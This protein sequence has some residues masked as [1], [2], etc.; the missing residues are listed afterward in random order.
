MKINNKLWTWPLLNMVAVYLAPK[1]L[2]K[3]FFQYSHLLK[4]Y[5]PW[6]NCYLCFDYDRLPRSKPLLGKQN[7]VEF[8]QSNGLIARV[9]RRRKLALFVPLDWW[10]FISKLSWF[11]RS[12]FEGLDFHGIDHKVQACVLRTTTILVASIHRLQSRCQFEL[13]L[14]QFAELK[15]LTD[16]SRQKLL[17]HT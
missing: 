12:R 11:R 14:S 1:W 7:S 3:S 13:T 15:S 10:N 6:R 4:S 17:T 9:A 16:S 2:F 5:F 8:Y